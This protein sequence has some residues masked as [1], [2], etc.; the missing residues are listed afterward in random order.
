MPDIF[1]E[2]DEDLRA[3]R[4]RRW[5]RRFG[6][7]VIAAAVAVVVGVGGW[8]AWKWF[9]QRGATATA[10]R[11]LAAQKI[12]DAR[13]GP[14]RQ[15]AVPLFAAIA[16]NGSHQYP[17]LARLRQAALLADAGDL[18]GASALWDA[19]ATDNGADKLLRDLADL[20]WSE[21]NLDSA[22]PVQLG[23]RL[24]RLAAPDNA[25]HGLAQEAEALLALRQGKPD[26]ARLTLKQLTQ[27]DAVP[28]GVR[29]RAQGLLAQLGPA[30]DAKAVK[31]GS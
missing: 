1:D 14:G 7:L 17:T 19:V 2:V 29:R 11:Y 16:A 8:E 10:T 12:A 26:A 5:T 13:P 3:E 27:D 4:L 15:A 30:A 21:H 25:W 9:D 28:E 6:P 31:G 20:E 22:D 23:A 18:K 24:Q